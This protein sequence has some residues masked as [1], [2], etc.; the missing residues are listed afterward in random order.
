MMPR[1][2]VGDHQTFEA[3]LLTQDLGQQPVVLRAVGAVY[4]VVGT[5]D[6]PRL[7]GLHDPLERR[8]ID[9]AE[10]PLIDLRTDPKSIILLV[11]GGIVLGR[12]ANPL[13]LGALHHWGGEFTGQPR[14]FGE[15]L[16]VPPAQRGPL[17]IDPRAEHDPDAQLLRPPAE[18]LTY[19]SEEL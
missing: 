16:K 7:R 19:R 5:H 17:H 4:L 9:L 11:V 14:I 2:P 6:R 18:R 12:G 3:P 1:T 15:I 13:A 8:Q 10:T